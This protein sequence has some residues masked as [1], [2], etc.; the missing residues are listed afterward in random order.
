MTATPFVP[1]TVQDLLNMQ[2]PE[3]SYQ[4]KVNTLFDILD[5]ANPEQTAQLVKFLVDR[6]ATF[7]VNVISEHSDE[8]E[9]DKVIAW[10]H[11]STC[12]QQIQA[13]MNNITDFVE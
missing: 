4:E 8:W 1:N 5:E 9:A 10:T 6:L 12:W 7:H 3:Q 13:I 2:Q 11:D